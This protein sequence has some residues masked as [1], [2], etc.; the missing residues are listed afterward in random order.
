MI[1]I[2]EDALG[3]LYLLTIDGKVLRIDATA[4]S[5]ADLAEPLGTLNFF[6]IAAFV[7]LYNAS[8]AG[9]DLAEPFGTLN[10]FDIAA[11]IDLYNAGCP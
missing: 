6:D 10:F 1:S 8:D 9:A 11:Y 4:C 2:G 7:D 5:S 3:E